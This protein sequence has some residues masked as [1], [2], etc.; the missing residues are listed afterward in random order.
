[1]LVTS[2]RAL[3]TSP[4]GAVPSSSPSQPAQGYTGGGRGGQHRRQL[5]TKAPKVFSFETAPK[6]AFGVTY[7]TD[8]ALV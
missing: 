6:A 2:P 1:V 4:C 7:T 8:P 3:A 5:E